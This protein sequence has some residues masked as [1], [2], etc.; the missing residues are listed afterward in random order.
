MTKRYQY[1]MKMRPF[2]FGA[3]PK[4]GFVRLVKEGIKKID[5][6]YAIIEYDRELTEKEIRSFELESFYVNPYPIQNER[7]N[8]RI[9]DEINTLVKK[10]Y[11]S[12]AIKNKKITLKDAIAIITSAG[13]EIPRDI[14]AMQK[15]EHEAEKTSSLTLIKLKAK[16]L[17]LKLSLLHL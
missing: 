6:Y 9:L 16:A 5:G 15:K 17:K 1:K 10:G 14:L 2:D 8:E 13:L 7:E 4:G 3:A 11:Y 12:D